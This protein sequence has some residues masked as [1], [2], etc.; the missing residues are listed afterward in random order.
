[1][2]AAQYSYPVSFFTI[3]ARGEWR[4][5]GNTWFDLA[6]TIEQKGYSLFNASIGIRT[7]NY[8][9]SFWERNLTNKRY[10]SYAYD[11]GAA[12]LGDPQTYGVTLGV[13]F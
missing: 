8:S 6:N 11:F 13:K 12:H 4:Y 9:L 5:L 7:K 10:I 2:L 3:T 1:M